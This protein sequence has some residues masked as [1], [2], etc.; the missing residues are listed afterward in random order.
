M[1]L[2]IDGVEKKTWKDILTISEW[3]GEIYSD[4]SSISTPDI[5][6]GSGCGKVISNCKSVLS[7]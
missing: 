7:W 4:Q 3:E 1:G 2:E 6:F 5:Y